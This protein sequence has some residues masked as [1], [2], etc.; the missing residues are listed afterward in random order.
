[1]NKPE[2]WRLI[3]SGSLG[4][5]QNM[6][7]DEALLSSFE[8]GSQPVFR[9]YG[10]QP[11]ALS[12]GRFQGSGDVLDLDRCRSDRL[13]VVRRI[14]GGGVIYHADELTYSL[15]CSPD[16]IPKTASIK[17]SFRILTGFLL[18]FYRSLG[19][20]AAYALDVSNN[21]EKLGQRTPFCFAGRESFDMIVNGKK[22]GGNAQ[23]RL[24]RVVF[25]HGS[26]PILNRMA[27]GLLYLRQRPAGVV[28][29]VTCLA[30]EGVATDTLFLKA[31]LKA[32]FC[33]TLQ[34]SLL[35]AEL[36]DHE[37][38]LAE[39]L[40]CEKYLNDTWNLGGEGL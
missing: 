26:I 11:A 3:D 34:T 21:A 23:R 24:K 39:R 30:A 16:Q 15:V 13:P 28:E 19:L 38:L 9:L 17:D 7:I 40:L 2:Q 1:M 18:Q 27:D 25:Q 5:P 12:L 29:R 22:I 31:A 32:A 4:G 6:A 14:S 20:D 10:W 36:T 37:Q 35:E 8:Q 33:S